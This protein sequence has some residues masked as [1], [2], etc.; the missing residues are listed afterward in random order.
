[1]RIQLLMTACVSALFAASASAADFAPSGR[2]RVAV[3]NAVEFPANIPEV[4]AKLRDVM[5]AAVKQHGYEQTPAG[6]ACVDRDCLKGL[7]LTTGATDVLVAVGGQN[8]LHG[9]HVELRIWN[10]ASDRDDRST[11][12]CNVCTGDQIVET[13]SGSVGQLLDRVPALHASIARLP[14]PAVVSRPPLVSLPPPVATSFPRWLPWTGV[15]LTAAGVAGGIW[16]L[17]L[18]NRW[19][20]GTPMPPQEAC[21]NRYNT[22]TWGVLSLAGA[23]LVAAGTAYVFYRNETAGTAEVALSPAGMALQGSF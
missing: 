18:D 9:Y 15:A 23:G 22:N 1:M 8:K 19:T 12:E 6:D 2:P 16:L 11:A 13:V 4:G 7:A 14:A 5:D 3:V 21:P 10:V 20:C 17:H